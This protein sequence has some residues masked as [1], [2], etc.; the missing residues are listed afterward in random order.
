MVAGGWLLASLAMAEEMSGVV[1]VVGSAINAQIMLTEAGEEKGPVVCA[2]DVGKKVKRLGAM[3]VKASGAWRLDKKG[4]KSCFEATE[5]A[6]LKTSSGR[7]ALVGTLSHKDGSYVVTGADGKAHVLEDIPGGLKKLDGEKVI[8]DIKP[9]ST[10][11]TK[12]EVFKVVTYAAH[13]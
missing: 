1:K 5:F 6:V 11:S 7:D 9:I 13:P 4:D 10:P 3:T 2:N 8:L 12:G